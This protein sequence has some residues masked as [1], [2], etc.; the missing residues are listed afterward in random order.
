MGVWHLSVSEFWR[1]SSEMWAVK[2]HTLWL[3]QHTNSSMKDIQR[4]GNTVKSQNMECHL[5]AASWQTYKSESFIQIL[6]SS[7]PKMNPNP[8]AR[9][10]HFRQWRGPGEILVTRLMAA[11]FRV[12]RWTSEMYRVTEEDCSRVFTTSSGHVRIAPTV[13]PQL[14]RQTAP[15]CF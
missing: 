9:Y 4:I 1:C 8:C 6:I 10:T 5:L 2:V 7:L 15:S 14:Q 3:L 12:L 13:P 11:P